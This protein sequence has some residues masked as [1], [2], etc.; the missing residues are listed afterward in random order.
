MI[1]NNANFKLENN[2]NFFPLQ[3]KKFSYLKWNND[4]K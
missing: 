3:N 1:E 2:A 4:G